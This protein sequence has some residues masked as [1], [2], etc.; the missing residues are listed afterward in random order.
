MSH[1]AQV[2]R[3]VIRH[4]L[5]TE[6]PGTALVRQDVADLSAVDPEVHDRAQPV[7][8]RERLSGPD[9]G[10]VRPQ[11]SDG[12]PGES[13]SFFLAEPLRHQ[14]PGLPLR[15]LETA[16]QKRADPRQPPGLSRK[17]ILSGQPQQIR[18]QRNLPR[19][20]ARGQVV[21]SFFRQSVVIHGRLFDKLRQ[22]R[23]CALALPGNGNSHFAFRFTEPVLISVALGEEQPGL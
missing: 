9:P 19:E 14:K 20:A 7:A 22:L 8:V 21:D 18:V 15:S 2:L 5:Q 4:L 13:Q 23:A 1:P 6:Y 12:L 16:P 3:Q 10:Q 17:D 11:R